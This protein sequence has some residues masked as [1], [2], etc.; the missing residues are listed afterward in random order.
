[1][2]SF[3]ISVGLF[4]GMSAFIWAVVEPSK[5]YYIIFVVFGYNNVL[6]LELKLAF[7]KKKLI[8]FF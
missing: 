4:N 8:N 6:Y 7:K 2:F 5:V 1:M 3:S